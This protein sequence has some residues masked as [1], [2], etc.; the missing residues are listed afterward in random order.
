MEPEITGSDI[1]R[2]AGRLSRLCRF[3]S[4][5]LSFFSL[6]LMLPVLLSPLILIGAFLS[7]GPFSYTG[8]ICALVLMMAQSALL[9]VS[10]RFI[11]QVFVD[12]AKRRPFY[13]SQAKHLLFAGILMFVCTFIEAIPYGLST[14]SFNYGSLAIGLELSKASGFSINLGTLLCSVSLLTVSAI[15]RHGY[16][17]QRISD[18]TI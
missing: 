4:H 2:S 3:S 5:L 11:T 12:I 18:D 10:L 7:V 13:I 17:L 14:L 8:S 1:E 6:I 15:F 16:L 9:S